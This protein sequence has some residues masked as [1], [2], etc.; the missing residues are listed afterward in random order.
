[1][2]LAQK[3]QIGI[4]L[5][6]VNICLTQLNEQLD[7]LEGLGMARQELAPT[8]EQTLSLQFNLT[9]LKLRL[10]EAIYRV[11]RCLCVGGE[12]Y[13]PIEREVAMIRRGMRGDAAKHMSQRLCISLKRCKA[14]LARLYPEIK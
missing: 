14:S 12:C 9:D 13:C 3:A 11:P 7:V 5:H 4:A 8:I 1:M 2:N 10:S 6:N